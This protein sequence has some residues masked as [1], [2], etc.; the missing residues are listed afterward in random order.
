M[1]QRIHFGLEQFISARAFN[2]RPVFF[3]QCRPVLPIEF[4]IKVFVPNQAVHFGK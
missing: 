3:Y 4:G 2:S 1:K